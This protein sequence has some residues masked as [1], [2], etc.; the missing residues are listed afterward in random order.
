MAERKTHIIQRALIAW[1]AAISLVVV[2]LL[3]G[4][5]PRVLP[6]FAMNPIVFV[7][8]QNDYTL[9]S[10]LSHHGVLVESSNGLLPILLSVRRTSADWFIGGPSVQVGP[11]R[12]SL[13]V[14]AIFTAPLS[15][16]LQLSD[17]ARPLPFS[18]NVGEDDSYAGLTLGRGPAFL[19]GIQFDT[20]STPL[21][22]FVLLSGPQNEAVLRA[23][24]S[25]GLQVMP[26]PFGEIPMP[27]ETP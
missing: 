7:G 8:D 14:V 21:H 26:N 17:G 11:D 19:G 25:G 3:A 13:F 20:H 10:P 2:A 24:R 16:G 23:S 18:L 12:G 22:P 4:A 27:S 1:E 6:S 9:R 15:G 5:A